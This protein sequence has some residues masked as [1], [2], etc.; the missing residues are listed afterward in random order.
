MNY[1]LIPFRLSPRGS[2]KRQPVRRIAA[3]MAACLLSAVPSAAQQDADHTCHIEWATMR[4][5][6]RLAT[7]VY[8]PAQ[9]GR[10]P[11]VLTRSPYN[12][13]AEASGSACDNEG[14]IAF[15]QNGYAA[16]NQDVRG[17]YRSEG[18]FDPFQQEGADG[19]DAVEWAA[20]Q[21]WSN[22]RVG[23]TGASY[24]GVTTWQAT[25]QAPPH[26]VTSVANITSSDYH[27]NWIYVNGALDLLVAQGWTYGY[28]AADTYRRH[29]DGTGTSPEETDRLV[30]S[31]LDEAKSDLL[32]R[33]VRTL[34][35][36]SLT[37]F[38]TVAPYYD[39]WLSHRS[40]A[41]Y[42]AKVDLESRYAEVTVPTLNTGSWYDVFQ[43]GTVKNFL[44]VRAK[45]ATERARDS[46]KLVMGCCGH[47]GT[48]GLIQWGPDAES[49]DATLTRRWFD[50]WLKGVDDGIRE[51]PAVQ[52]VVLV[53]P[54]EGTEGDAFWV[55][56]DRYPLPDTEN[57]KFS[58]RSGGRANTR[59]G[60]G[61]LDSTGPASGSPDQ[62][63]YDPR[64]PVPTAGGNLCCGPLLERGAVDQSEIELRD[65][66]LVYTSEPLAEDLAVIGPVTVSLWAASSA[67]DT[68]F[69]AKLVD[70]HPDGI[71]HNVLDRIV[72]AR[73]RG[74]SRKPPQPITP[75]QIYEYTIDLG[76]TGTMFRV[77]HRVRLEISSS[78]FP[79]YDRN[80]N[81]GVP[82]EDESEV[83]KAHQTIYHDAEHPSFLELPVARGVAIPSGTGAR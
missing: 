74:G 8:L 77:G 3:G 38:R 65:D 57:V 73:F 44:G 28:L 18:T 17:R 29:L 41:P 51:M 40:F 67:Y 61:V 24:V 6:V 80:P 26:L 35:L 49:P 23:V 22:G 14:M 43:V 82:I 34:P 33:W 20:A 81:T 68:D 42:W 39:E 59:N 46:A 66:V 52:L 27:N 50:Y 37:S 1:M 47:T 15:A 16:L 45:G 10:Y 32:S 30:S 55:T 36:E 31:W 60:D 56:G 62:Y 53:P 69:T 13:G 25:V 54:N 78:N 9:P 70:V 5:G 63:V 76:H 21:P 79:H 2:G 12:R 19:Y 48:Q 75:G 64:D 83:L 11:V 4:D 58:L 7:E 71:A 72:R